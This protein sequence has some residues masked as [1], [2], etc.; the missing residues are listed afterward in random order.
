MMSSVVQAPSIFLLWHPVRIILIS[1]SECGRKKATHWYHTFIPSTKRRKNVELLSSSPECLSDSFPSYSVEKYLLIWLAFEWGWDYCYASQSWLS[2][3]ELHINIT[4]D[5]VYM[6]VHVSVW[7]LGFTCGSQRTVLAVSPWFPFCLRWSLLCLPAYIRTVGPLTSISSLT[8][9]SHL[10]R[11][12]GILDM[13]C[14]IWPYMVSMDPNSGFHN[15]V[16][17]VLQSDNHIHA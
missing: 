17:N 11:S 12:P 14:G 13:C 7:E 1:K 10:C 15:Y 5:D 8:S 9:V 2:R 4:V 16:E 3:S 6:Y